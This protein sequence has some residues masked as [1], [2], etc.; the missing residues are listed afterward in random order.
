MT[1]EHA[2]AD[3]GERLAMSGNRVVI[4]TM[5]GSW[6]VAL[7]D[8]LDAEGLSV[9]EPSAGLQSRMREMGMPVRASGFMTGWTKS[10][11]SFHACTSNTPAGAPNGF[12]NPWSRGVFIIL[13]V[14]RSDRAC[15]RTRKISG[16]AI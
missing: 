14:S 3:D 13:S 12:C 10:P 6:G 4:L 5:G 16:P 11:R 8:V 9:P 7:T 15:N 1:D 2:S